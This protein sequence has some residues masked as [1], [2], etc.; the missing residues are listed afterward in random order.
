MDYLEQLQL[1]VRE[2]LEPM[3]SRFQVQRPNYWATLPPFV[4]DKIT[5]IFN[6]ETEDFYMLFQGGFTK[7]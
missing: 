6:N 1:V 7:P 4:T 2:G 3:I 5:G